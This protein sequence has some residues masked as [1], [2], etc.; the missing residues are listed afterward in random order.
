MYENEN[1][2]SPCTTPFSYEEITPRETNGL[3]VD[4][5][6]MIR[7]LLAKHA[8]ILELNNKNQELLTKIVGLTDMIE[9]LQE[10]LSSLINNQSKDKKRKIE[11]S[12]DEMTQ[13]S[14]WA[15]KLKMVHLAPVPNKA[16]CCMALSN[17]Q[18]W[19]AQNNTQRW[20]AIPT[21]SIM[22]RTDLC[23]G[24][25]IRRSFDGKKSRKKWEN[26]GRTYKNTKDKKNKS[27]R[28][29]V[30][31]VYFE[32]MDELL[33]NKPSNCSPHTFDVGASTKTRRKP[34]RNVSLQYVEVKKNYYDRKVTAYEEYTRKKL[35]IMER[36]V[37]L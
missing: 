21:G 6:E 7:T 24:R 1:G 4:V 31:F 22:R 20:R 16:Q 10:Q 36:K 15:M 27:G 14:Y 37:I 30:R 2:R 12:S 35:E 34:K 32:R 13:R 17:S 28:Y 23:S 3:A 29:P 8:Q 9:K 25:E 26:L 33:G 5:E 18:Y 11:L 19:R